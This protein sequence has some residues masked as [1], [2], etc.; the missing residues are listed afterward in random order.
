[1]SFFLQGEV[2]NNSNSE[3]VKFCEIFLKSLKDA[4]AGATISDSSLIMLCNA[5]GLKLTAQQIQVCVRL[6]EKR[7]G[8]LYKL[9]LNRIRNTGYQVLI[10]DNQ[11]HRVNE[12]CRDKLYKQAKKT[13]QRLGAIDLK[14]CSADLRQTVTSKALA[15]SQIA[16]L[17]ESAL[18]SKVFTTKDV[19]KI[20]AANN[21]L[22]ALAELRKYGI[23]E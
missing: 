20:Q 23:D 14:R 18:D 8:E 15:A 12:E 9:R 13:E 17:I 6:L 22:K 19:G 21:E 11:Y 2:M 1:V 7:I 4:Q 10:G 3:K 5:E 16:Q